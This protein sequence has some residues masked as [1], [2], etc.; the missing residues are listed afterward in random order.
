MTTIGLSHYIGLVASWRT[1]SLSVAVRIVDC[2]RS[3]GRVRYLITPVAGTGQQW[4]QDG[5]ILPTDGQ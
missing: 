4:I 2:K 1:G 3:Y 5:L